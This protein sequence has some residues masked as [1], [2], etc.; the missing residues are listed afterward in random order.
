MRSPFKLETGIDDRLHDRRHSLDC[1]V[2][3]IGVPMSPTSADYVRNRNCMANQNRLL[4]PDLFWRHL[5]HIH[6][7]AVVRTVGLIPSISKVLPGVSCFERNSSDKAQKYKGVRKSSSFSI[8]RCRTRHTDSQPVFRI[9]ACRFYC[10][11]KR[12]GDLRGT[13][14]CSS[15]DSHDKDANNSQGSF[16]NLFRI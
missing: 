3:K 14:D 12:N 11:L 16:S 4:N 9:S 15:F 8:I 2:E 10:A 7:R 6:I 5:R 1:R 13:W